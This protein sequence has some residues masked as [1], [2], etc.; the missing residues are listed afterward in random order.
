MSTEFEGSHFF[1]DNQFTVPADSA[2]RLEKLS[3]LG[4]SYLEL[5]PQKSGGPAF[6]DGQR[7]P[8][9]S[10][11]A[12]RSISELG[13]SVVR[14]LNQLDPGQLHRVVN[15]ADA[16][17][18]DPYT[19]LPNLE[20]TGH[21]LNNTTVGLNGRGRQALENLQSLLENDGF[22][23]SVLAQ[24][25]SGLNDLSPEIATTWNAGVNNALRNDMPGS[26]YIFGAVGA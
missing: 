5:E 3:A 26:V 2:V 25:A 17:L 19:V 24:S 6:T 7:V 13:A 4:E 14:T 11:V 15:E 10:I 20:R 12:P 18:P 9:E 16:A 8:T 21:V 23:G 22:V 1:V